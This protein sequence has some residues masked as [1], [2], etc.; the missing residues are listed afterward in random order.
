MNFEHPAFAAAMRAAGISVCA[1]LA[2]L[3]AW[4]RLRSLSGTARRFL[5]A[6]SVLA[7]FTPSMLAGYSLLPFVV[8]WPPGS[9]GRELFYGAFL[10]IRLAPVAL[11]CLWLM[12]AGPEGAARHTGRLAGCAGF[13]WRLREA[14]GAPWM[15]LSLTFLLAFQEFDLA[16]SWGIR[17]WTVQ[18]YDAQI[19]GFAIT[20]TL[21]MVA[22]PLAIQALV[23]L[24]MFVAFRSAALSGIAPPSPSNRP[25][26]KSAAFT[27]GVLPP[28]LF[29]VIPAVVL[30]RLSG[31]GFAA[32]FQRPT[33]VKEILHSVIS[34]AIASISAW[35][36]SGLLRGA[37]SIPFLA[38]GLLGPL[39]IG[40]LFVSGLSSFPVLAET[41]LPWVVALTLS[42]LPVAFLL[43]VLFE[44]PRDGAALYSARLCGT[45][46][47][48]WHLQHLR[49]TA[50]LLLL[51]CAA[52]A[53]FTIGG[54][55]APPQ[56]ATIF[57]RVF[58]LMHYGQSSILSVTVFVAVL[59]PLAAMGF[60]L[61]L[62]RWYVRRYVR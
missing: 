9:I 58:N 44:T 12:K 14:G 57:S 3:Y 20:D 48:A 18:V 26:S 25:S 13:R 41:V 34:G 10:T 4:P 36:G 21:P 31:D 16:T 24:G 39:L 38:L 42:L 8:G 19:G 40:L 15:A 7:Y 17:S 61:L 29:V 43:R 1:T 30:L 37:A 56:F 62:A 47:I 5:L 2:A 55:L 45:R 35:A 27:F 59:T 53:D 50:A 46:Q 28:L 6:A 11:L 22:L 33:M 51:F 49:S 23:I 60:L 52:Y 32:F 54:L